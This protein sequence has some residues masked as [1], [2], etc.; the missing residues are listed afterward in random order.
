MIQFKLLGI[1]YSENATSINCQFTTG[2]LVT[3]SNVVPLSVD[4]IKLPSL[5][6]A[7]KVLFPN[8]I[9]INKPPVGEVAL[10]QE[11]PLSVDRT[12]IPEEPTATK[13]LFPNETSRTV[14]VVGD[15]TLRLIT[16][17]CLR[18]RFKHYLDKGG[19]NVDSDSFVE[20]I[21]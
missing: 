13:I 11:V 9:P 5:P 7:T 14:I 8:P 15:V 4:L 2:R 18:G 16:Q 19:V 3:L 6:T 20:L 21:K 1:N 10:S 17:Y 12:I